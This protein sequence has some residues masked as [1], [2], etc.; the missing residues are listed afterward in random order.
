MNNLSA[1]D[2]NC[3]MVNGAATVPVKHK[4]TGLQL[5]SADLRALIGLRP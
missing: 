4:I 1:A 5:G 2:I 3:H